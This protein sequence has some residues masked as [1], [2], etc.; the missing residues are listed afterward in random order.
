MTTAAPIPTVQQVH[1]ALQELGIESDILNGR[2]R[3]TTGNRSGNLE[4]L[5]AR[6]ADGFTAVLDALDIIGPNPP[7]VTGNG[8]TQWFYRCSQTEPTRTLTTLVTI[9]SEGSQV[10]TY[11]TAGYE[12]IEPGSLRHIPVISWSDRC[13]MVDS[14]LDGSILKPTPEVQP[15]PKTTEE[16]LEHIYG[17]IEIT[18]DNVARAFEDL[19]Q[20]QFRYCKPWNQWLTWDSRWSPE[21]TDLPYDR[22]RILTRRLNMKMNK[23]SATAGFCAGVERM[24]RA[25]RAFATT[26][27]QWDSNNWLLNLPAGT[28][29]LKTDTLAPH[30]R[31]DYIT[32]IANIS[33]A[34]GPHPIFDL[35]MQEITLGDENL[36]KYHQRSLGACLSGAIQDNFLLFWYG[37]GQ[38]GKNTFGDLIEWI[39][40]DYAKVIPVETLMFDKNGSRHPTDLAN[41]RGARLA[42]SSE[43]EEGSHFNEQRI[44]SLTGDT[45]ISA[46]F[47][48]GDFFEFQ[49]THKHLIYGNHRPMLR[50]VD[51]ALR[52]RMHIIPFKAYFPPDTKD[53]EMFRKLQAEA[54]QILQWLIDGHAMWLEDGYLKK[55]SA[56]QTET[57]AYFDAQSTPEMWVAECCAERPTEPSFRGSAKDLYSSFKA[58]KESRGE[59]VMSQTRWGEWMT[60]RYKKV[61]DS[62][63]YYEGIQVVA[64]Q[65]NN[66]NEQR[67]YGADNY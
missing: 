6:G 35:F 41:L 34:P 26:P 33:P 24:A 60:L 17:M 54:P 63:I 59:G 38:N 18:Q 47:M 10:E 48:R 4:C 62:K 20:D 16:N 5:E 46:R 45:N 3:I 40:G 66:A 21:V 30:R 8:V 44:K 29:D 50:I 27:A 56:V 1:D 52:A 42:I 14:I 43:V 12:R 32:K 39:L 31:E 9:H 23:S 65:E 22:S 15:A 37:T 55:C 49:R 11:P 67:R 2:L 13:R 28:M 53:P 36:V 7:C 19:Y 61:K 57:D 25:S 51:P 64:P 58:W